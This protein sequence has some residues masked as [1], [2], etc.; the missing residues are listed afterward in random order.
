MSANKSD[1]SWQRKNRAKRKRNIF[2]GLNNSISLGQKE[3]E[4]R[5]VKTTV[6]I[7]SPAIPYLVI[8]ATDGEISTRMPI[9]DRIYILKV[10]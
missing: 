6:A 2:S 5:R 9:V 4:K 3:V 7:S 8:T 10:C 1:V